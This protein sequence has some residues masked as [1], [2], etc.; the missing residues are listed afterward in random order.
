M[1]PMQMYPHIIELS[2]C[3]LNMFVFEFLCPINLLVSLGTCS[4]PKLSKQITSLSFTYKT[5]QC[6]L[7]SA[8]SSRFIT[9]APFFIF[10]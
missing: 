9:Y 5:I 4:T 7:T 1:N 2:A 6:V 3:I 8:C 10:F